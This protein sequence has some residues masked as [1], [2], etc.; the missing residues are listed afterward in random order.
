MARGEFFK[1]ASHD[2]ECDRS[3]VRRCLDVFRQAGRRAVLVF[4]RADIIDDTGRVMFESPDHVSSSSPRPFQRLGRVLWSSSYAHP[5]WGVIRA[6]ALR[7]TGLMGCIEA[8]QVVLAELAMLGEL[9]EIPLVLYRLRRHPGC[10]T[11][12]HHTAEALLAWHDPARTG[13]RI[14]LPHHER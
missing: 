10:A 12:T 11:E 1:W 5:L 3:L 6:D 2:D 7:Q 4:S 9:I 13:T 8:D 14:F